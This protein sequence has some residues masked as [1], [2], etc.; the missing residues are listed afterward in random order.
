MKVLL[1]L[2]LACVASLS[3]W[4]VSTKGQGGMA[5]PHQSTQIDSLVTKPQ[6]DSPQARQAEKVIPVSKEQSPKKDS[7]AIALDSLRLLQKSYDSLSRVCDTLRYEYEDGLLKIANSYRSRQYSK[8]RIDKVLSRIKDT[9]R[10]SLQAKDTILLAS[11]KS[12]AAY[13]EEFIKLLRQMHEE[14]NN[15]PKPTGI[16]I[17]TD[18]DKRRDAL[19]SKLMSTKY[20]RE[21]KGKDDEVYYLSDRYDEAVRIIEQA[22]QRK[23]VADFSL[24]LKVL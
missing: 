24:L 21:V 11:L 7:L 14:E 4:A 17:Q 10:E 8:D 20:Y 13:N 12:Y 5:Y 2:G 1:S 6:S 22:H 18:A 15:R 16:V 23:G 19:L 9:V 3:A